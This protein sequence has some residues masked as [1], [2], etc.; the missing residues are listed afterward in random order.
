MSKSCLFMIY[1]INI[2]TAICQTLVNTRTMHDKVI[3]AQ[4]R[5]PQKKFNLE[6]V[7]T[8][9]FVFPCIRK[10]LHL[11]GFKSLFLI[12]GFKWKN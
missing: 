9:S 8:T 1:F 11:Y 4:P 7:L 12:M 2:K 3:V 5:K 10:V 6:T